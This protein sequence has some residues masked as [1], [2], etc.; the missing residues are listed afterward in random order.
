MVSSASSSG[1]LS[2]TPTN[3]IFRVAHNDDSINAKAPTVA[4]KSAICTTMI[5]GIRLPSRATEVVVIF[6]TS[7][8]TAGP[9]VAKPPRAV[10]RSRR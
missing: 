1:A 8:R 5:A 2:G 7:K 10:R 6:T 3:V 9:I 4:A